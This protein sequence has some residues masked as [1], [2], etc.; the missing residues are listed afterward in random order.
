MTHV[1][2]PV[3]TPARRA[4]LAV[5]SG[6]ALVAKATGVGFRRIAA[7]LGRP[8]E[9][10]RGWLRR[11]ASRAE[12]T[13]SVFTRWLR[14]LVA[15]PVMPEP[16]GSAWADAVTAILACSRVVA[17]RS[18]L[19]AVTPREVAALAGTWYAR[20]TSTEHDAHP[21]AG[22]PLFRWFRSHRLA[23]QPG[24]SRQRGRQVEQEAL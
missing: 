11:F 23:W 5:V 10:V 7:G 13:G 1:L 4:D 22:S 12:W 24:C 18:V 17:V 3:A 19:G 14:A 6:V 9:T 8:V 20:L 15:N 16:A 21:T 2:L